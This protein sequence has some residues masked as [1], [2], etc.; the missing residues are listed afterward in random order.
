MTREIEPVSYEPATRVLLEVSYDGT[1]YRG[2]QIQPHS[3]S[4]QQALQETLTRLYAGHAIHAIGSSRTDAGVH[5]LGFAASY[6][7]PKRPWIP[8]ERLEGILNRQLPPSVRIRSVREVP[9]GFHTRYDAVGKAY[10]YVLNTGLE[11]PFSGRYS[12]LARRPVDPEKIR[13]A[14]SHLVG[15]HDYSSFVVERSMIDDAVRTIY[16]IDVAVHGPYLCVTFK[17]NGF[18]YKMIRCLFG[19]LEAVGTGV[20]P[21]AATPQILA[22]RNRCDAPETAPAHGLFLMKVFFDEPELHAWRLTEVPFL[23]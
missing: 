18:L 21:V 14:A 8:L 13:A 1:E 6:L 9:L 15:T 2:W 3:P 19:L 23:A 5:A 12:W 16:A 22:A 11:T 7:V 20:L 4:V 10:T 17:G